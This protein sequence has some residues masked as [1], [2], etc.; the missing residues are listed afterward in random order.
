MKHSEIES[1]ND[2]KLNNEIDKEEALKKFENE[3]DTKTFHDVLSL[4]KKI[5]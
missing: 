5:V 1:Q 4:K 3:L 2:K